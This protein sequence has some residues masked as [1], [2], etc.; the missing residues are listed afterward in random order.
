MPDHSELDSRYFIDNDI[1]NCPYCN[2]RHVS[3]TVRGSKVFNWTDSKLC[4][5]YFV[6]CHSCENLSM[7]LSFN[8]IPLSGTGY[9]GRSNINVDED[10]KI[11]DLFFYSVP[12][13]FFAIDS[14]VP[15][16][17]RELM[18][19]AE[20]SLK[21]NYLTGASVCARKM[22]YEL[23]I[24]EGAQGEN[25]EDRI[26]SLKSVRTDVD[27]EYFD[28]LLTIQQVTSNKVH[29]ESYDGWESKHLKL[30]LST[31]REIF[32]NMY[33]I[34]EIKKQKRKSILELKEK[35]IGKTK[36]IEG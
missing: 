26:K 5:V 20:G 28:T 25:Y 22:I 15:K 9:S 18:T 30:I 17:L 11:D 27:E 34:P 21:S 7:H 36:G 8:E 24:I 12:T 16:V 31:L 13:S 10:I 4:Y 14:R 35:I 29:E 19:E 33:V 23:A 2:L 6:F 32:G 1:Y 3:Y